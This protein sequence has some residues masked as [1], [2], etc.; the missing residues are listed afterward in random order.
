MVYNGRMMG[1]GYGYSGIMGGGFGLIIMA[2]VVI[3]LILLGI[4][5]YKQINK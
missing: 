3:D 4:W 2:I 1:Y 5:L